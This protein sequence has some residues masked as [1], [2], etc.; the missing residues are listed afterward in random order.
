MTV[1]FAELTG[2]NAPATEKGKTSALKV[3]VVF[4]AAAGYSTNLKDMEEEKLCDPALLRRFA[5]YMVDHFLTG[6]NA[7][8]MCDSA[9][10]YLSGVFTVIKTRFPSN[11][12]YTS[13]GSEWYKTLRKELN[14]RI[15]LRCIEFGEEVASKSYPVGRDLLRE[16]SQHLLQ[17]NSTEGLYHRFELVMQFAS[18]GG[19][20]GESA[21]V[22]AN[23]CYWDSLLQMLRLFRQSC[24]RK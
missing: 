7:P 14:S 20:S 18:G 23:G 15:V 10:Q 16:I 2:G 24:W 1:V 21:L 17:L 9:K 3:F 6:D 13:A 19:R 12:N 5:T 22:S 8:L 4:L 11:Q